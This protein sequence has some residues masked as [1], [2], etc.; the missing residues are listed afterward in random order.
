MK[1][2]MSICRK[3]GRP[4]YGSDAVGMELE[5]ELPDQALSDINLIRATAECAYDQ[6]RK[7]VDEQLTDLRPADRSAT[8]ALPDRQNGRQDRPPAHRD[9]NGGT[10]PQETDQERDR[11]QYGPRTNEGK[12]WRGSPAPKNSRELLG[13][14]R[15]TNRQAELEDIGR[16]MRLPDRILEWTEEEVSDV[17]QAVTATDPPRNGHYRNGAAAY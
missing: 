6:I 8:P 11:R 16:R 3:E 4:D 14:S 10:W 1:L 12:P 9:A 2:R 13:W 15:R 7:L 5:A 17:Y